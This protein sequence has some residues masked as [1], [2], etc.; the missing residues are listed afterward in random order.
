MLNLTC[1]MPDLFFI[2]THSIWLQMLWEW[3]A[4]ARVT[5]QV[6]LCASGWFLLWLKSQNQV[7]NACNKYWGVYCHLQASVDMAVILGQFPSN[8][9]ETV[10]LLFLSL[11]PFRRWSVIYV[12]CVSSQAMRWS[13][14]TVQRWGWAF[15]TCTLLTI[16][17]RFSNCHTN[18]SRAHE[19]TMV[20][21]TEDSEENVT[22]LLQDHRTSRGAHWI[23]RCQM[24]WKYHMETFKQTFLLWKFYIKRG[25]AKFGVEEA[26]SIL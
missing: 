2:W 14:S 19:R 9:F 8:H 16:S 5:S 22:H 18:W 4:T 13:G 24:F 26:V 6:S 7:R 20:H 17:R 25:L 15:N 1:L 21:V 23:V 12:L 3:F 10:F 11:F